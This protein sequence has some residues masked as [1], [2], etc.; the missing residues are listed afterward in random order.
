MKEGSRHISMASLTVFTAQQD[1]LSVS[2]LQVNTKQPAF[3][4]ATLITGLKE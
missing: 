3:R 1:C 2:K 4:L